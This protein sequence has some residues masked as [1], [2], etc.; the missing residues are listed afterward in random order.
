MPT[1]LSKLAG[2]ERPRTAP[3]SKLHELVFDHNPND[4]VLRSAGDNLES[5]GRRAL[6]IERE[7][8]VKW[9]V[10]TKGF[11]YMQLKQFIAA[12]LR[13]YATWKEFEIKNFNMWRYTSLCCSILKDKKAHEKQL[14][15][16]RED[17]AAIEE[18]EKMKEQKQQ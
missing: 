17:E 2:V 15:K 8:I 14:K 3:W 11:G 5:V 1:R 13:S 10:K 18:S 16:E 7:H 12:K 4:E 6:E 9:Q